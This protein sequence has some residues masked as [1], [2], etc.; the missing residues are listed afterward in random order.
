MSGDALKTLRD[1][2]IRAALYTQRSSALKALVHQ[3]TLSAFEKELPYTHRERFVAEETQHRLRQSQNRDLG[4][5]QRVGGRYLTPFCPDYPEARLGPHLLRVCGTLNANRTLAIVGSRK[6]S[7]AILSRSHL[8][9]SLCAQARIT[10]VSG[11][12][13]GVDIEAT[14]AAFRSMG[15]TITVLGSGLNRP[16]PRTHLP[17]FNRLLG[18]SN[19]HCIVSQFACDQPPKNWTYV[20][21][22]H[23]IADL[24]DAVVVMQA[25]ARSGALY[26]ARQAL[27]TNK[28]VYCWHLRTRDVAMQGC[29]TL[30]SRG[31]EPVSLLV[32]AL[33]KNYYLRKHGVSDLQGEILTILSDGPRSVSELTHTLGQTAEDICRELAIMYAMNWLEKNVDGTW[34]RFGLPLSRCGTVWL[35][36]LSHSSEREA[37]IV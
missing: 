9:G 15:F 27:A 2:F 4:S 26:A 23:L 22:N 12:A 13:F 14:M 19:E 34:S 37:L 6:S 20:K 36:G 32:Q 11:G 24:A 7:S 10:V 18:R 33:L 31:A 3:R 28:K 30:L 25:G 35:V 1:S 21:R 16:S 17:M 8:L 5:L 29:R